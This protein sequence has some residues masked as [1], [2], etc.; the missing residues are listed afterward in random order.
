MILLS[1]YT[2]SNIKILP[3]P[4]KN[5]LEPPFELHVDNSCV[6][7]EKTSPGSPFDL[8]DYKYRV[9]TFITNA[10]IP[11]IRD[12]SWYKSPPDPSWPD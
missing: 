12:T 3:N 11:I 6:E 9:L 7:K 1:L 4:C 2:I 8:K 5:L 10:K